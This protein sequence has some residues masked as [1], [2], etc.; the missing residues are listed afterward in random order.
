MSPKSYKKGWFWPVAVGGILVVTVVLLLIW[1]WIKPPVPPQPPAPDSSTVS[2]FT[3]YHGDHLGSVALVTNEFGF[4]TQAESYFPYGEIVSESKVNENEVTRYLYTHQERDDSEFYY[5]GARYYDP[6][7]ARFMSVDPID[8]Y[9]INS[10][11]YVKNSPISFVDPKGLFLE[12]TTPYTEPIFQMIF[13]RPR[14]SHVGEAITSRKFIKWVE[15]KSLAMLQHEADYRGPA[16]SSDAGGP[17]RKHRYVI[18]PGNPG[19]IID[20]R[21]FLV[22]GERGELFGL[23]VELRQLSDSIITEDAE[24]ERTVMD[25]EDFYSNALGVEFFTNFYDFN[26]EPFWEQLQDYFD[27]RRAQY[28]QYLAQFWKDSKTIPEE[29]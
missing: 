17:E 21:H 28:E 25:P 8:Q 22:V 27:Y 23:G 2:H 9:P 20:M 5:Y 16:S 11:N 1:R 13:G 12:R 10:Y 24:L 6:T 4:V 26:G 7:S 29:N 3:I 19:A 14:D 18:D 15:G